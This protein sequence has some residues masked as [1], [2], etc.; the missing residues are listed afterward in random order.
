MNWVRCNTS[1]FGPPADKRYLTTKYENLKV[2][3]FLELLSIFIMQS[4]Q[5]TAS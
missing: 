5:I 3:H 4:H 2:M 1:V